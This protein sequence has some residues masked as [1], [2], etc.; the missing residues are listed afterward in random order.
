MPRVLQKTLGM[1]LPGSSEDIFLPS[2]HISVSLHPASPCSH[3]NMHGIMSPVP[4]VSGARSQPPT[5]RLEKRGGCAHIPA[6]LAQQH[7][8]PADIKAATGAGTE[9]SWSSV[10]TCYHPQLA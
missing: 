2:F 6:H 8:S 1:T 10:I 4:G 3:K 9:G 7:E 5:A